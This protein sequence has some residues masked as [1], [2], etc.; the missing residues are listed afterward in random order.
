[1]TSKAT[2]FLKDAAA[3]YYNGHP[4]ISDEQ[5]DALV[6]A[7]GYYNVGSTPTTN[8]EKHYKRLYSLQKHYKDQGEAP[9]S[10]IFQYKTTCSPKLDGAAISLLYIDGEL[11]R[12]LTRGDGIQGQ[13]VTDKFLGSCVV[14]TKINHTGILQ[15]SG[16]IVAPKEVPN[17]RNYA[18]GA[19]NLKDV[20]EFK[21]RAISFFAYDCYPKPTNLYDDDMAMLSNLGFNTVKDTD[22]HYIYPTDGTVF[23]INDNSIAESLGYTSK[24]PKFAYALKERQGTYDTEILAVEWNTGRTGRV[25]PVAILEPV[26]IDGKE[27]SRATL[28]NPGFIESLGLCIGDTVAIRLAGMIIP[29]VVHKVNA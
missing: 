13:V 26:T 27:V 20:N 4:I 1:M 5:F 24:H 14:P 17:A 8:V 21:T 16:E 11:V 9:L 2:Q 7:T 6:S 28:N 22:I 10:S 15:V 25:T 18:A 12:A 19:L 3:A 29:E 23:R